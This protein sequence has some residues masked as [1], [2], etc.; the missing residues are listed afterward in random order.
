MHVPG[1]SAVKGQMSVH[2][3]RQKLAKAVGAAAAPAPINTPSLRAENNGKDTTVNL[4]P[5]AGGSSAVW[6]GSS[7]PT[8]GSEN[9]KSNEELGPLPGKNNS[10][11][12][13]SAKPAPWAKPGSTVAEVEQQPTHKQSW[14]AAADSDDEDAGGQKNAVQSWPDAFRDIPDDPPAQV[15]ANDNGPEK[16]QEF[17]RGR[18]I[19]PLRVSS[20][21]RG[22]RCVSHLIALKIFILVDEILFN[23]NLGE[24]RASTIRQQRPSTV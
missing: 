16:Q 9:Q 5:T 24:A 8:A 1:V 21:R 17:P 23:L 14:A 15:D 18:P 6:G 13:S 4:V 20:Q 12:S 2:I 19:P 10:S 3:G 22:L 7:T 11:L